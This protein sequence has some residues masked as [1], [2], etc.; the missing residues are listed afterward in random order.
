VNDL[1]NR[2]LDTYN[3]LEARERWLVT[4]AAV[5]LGATLAYL[6]V[7]GPLLNA[8]DSGGQ[9]LVTAD[10]RLALM[11]RMRREYDDLH[12]RLADVEQ[13]IER[14]A[15]GNL[16]TT[17]ETLARQAQVAVE[18]MEPQ[19]SPQHPKYKETKVE[20]GLKSV[21]LAQTV[22]YLHQIEVSPQALSVKSLRLRTRPDTPDLLDVTFTVSSFEP[23]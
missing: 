9:R 18:S 6:L 20:V 8:S 5:M 23:I 10:Q 17:L 3:G 11:E 21:T 4:A 7:I 16:R 13:R 22:K 2:L 1:W 14:G 19:A 15:R 12:G